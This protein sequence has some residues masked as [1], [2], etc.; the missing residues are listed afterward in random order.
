[1][2][3][4]TREGRGPGGV[5]PAGLQHDQPSKWGSPTAV[6]AIYQLPG[7]NALQTA[8]GVRKLMAQMK[9]RFPEGVDLCD[10]AGP[11]IAGQRRHEGSLSKPW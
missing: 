11:D 10:I 6:I 2:R 4:R 1:M 7:S 3:D 8:E 9:D 5:G